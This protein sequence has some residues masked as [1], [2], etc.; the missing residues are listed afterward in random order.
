MISVIIL[1]GG[2]GSRFYHPLPK[3]FHT[4]VGKTIIEHTVGRFNRHPQIK[5]IF[6][7]INEGY[8]EHEVVLKMEDETPKLKAVV[9]NG[10]SR[11][12]SVRN[13]LEILPQKEEFILVHDGTRPFVSDETINRCIEGLVT[14][15]A[16]YP[17]VPL[18]DSII[19]CRE[20][21]EFAVAI[22]TRSH[23]LRGQTPQGF[24]TSVLREAHHLAELDSEV[25]EIVANDCGLVARYGLCPIRVVQ[26]NREN[27]K[28]TYPED[29]LYFRDFMDG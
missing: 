24:R 6:L 15:D 10:K 18:V 1:A 20:E 27:I 9:K 12:Q 28:I 25:D 5:E 23:Y 14:A 26:G 4:V 3:Q 17:A 19:Y 11:R 22:P 16:V 7:V 29:L 21:R 8:L 13:A 2:L